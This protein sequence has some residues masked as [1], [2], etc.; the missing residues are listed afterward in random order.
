MK[1]ILD[2]D[3]TIF[4]ADRF[5]QEALFSCFI[6][7]KNEEAKIDP[8]EVQEAYINFRKEN[9]IFDINFFIDFIIK[10]FKLK[11]VD[12]DQ[13]FLEMKSKIKS[14][15]KKEYL[16]IFEKIGRENIFILSKGEHNFQMFK[17]TLSDIIDKVDK[18]SIVQESKRD[19][20]LS[21][22]NIW[23]GE[24]VIFVDD[25][26]ENLILGDAPDNL[27]QIFVGDYS[28]LSEEQKQKLKTHNI[29][30]CE[31]D[32]H[33]DKYFIKSDFEKARII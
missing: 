12:T 32:S 20:V 9:D 27:M 1:A 10:K 25:K 31:K 13:I 14:F 7:Q 8:R 16:A 17:I 15:I 22:C 18:V 2:F 26:I 28:K 23:R 4:D 33:L 6:T 11:Q 24:E 19:L 21:H 3:D 29:T 5:K 30:V